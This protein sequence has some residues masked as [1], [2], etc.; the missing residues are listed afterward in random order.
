MTKLTPARKALLQRLVNESG[1]ILAG[2]LT[3]T[4]CGTGTR[5]QKDGLVVWIDRYASKKLKIT[6]AGRKALAE[7]EA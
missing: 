4:E 7:S 2:R 6:D 1:I 5:A 3:A